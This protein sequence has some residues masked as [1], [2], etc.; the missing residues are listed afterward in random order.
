MLTYEDCVGMCD[1]TP[2][3]IAAIAAH[4][5]VPEI[6]AAELAQLLAGSSD[7]ARTI[8]RYLR[9]DMTHALARGD[10]ARHERLARVL[11]TFRAAHPG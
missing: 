5:H 2:E 10:R 7:G 11:A 4:E 1:L 3:E 9:E 6:Y 8:E